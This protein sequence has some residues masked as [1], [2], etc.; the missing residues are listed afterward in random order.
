MK[1]RRSVISAIIEWIVFAVIAFMTISA[2]NPLF[3][4]KSTY[5]SSAWPSTST[6]N[7]F[8]KMKRNSVDVLF[9]GSSVAANA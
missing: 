4:P 9:I 3:Y 7:G 2:V 6:Y 5:V 8:Y 1:K